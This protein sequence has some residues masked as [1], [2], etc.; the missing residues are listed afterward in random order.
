LQKVGGLRYIKGWRIAIVAT[1][2]KT[3]PEQT[4]LSF[5]A[6]ML[7]ALLL[8]TEE[9]NG[10]MT[11]ST[12]QL[13]NLLRESRLL[14]PNQIDVLDKEFAQLNGTA[15]GGDA[16]ALSQWLISR[17]AISP[18]QSKILLAG[19]SGPFFY[20]EYKVFDRVESGR[21]AGMFRAFHAPSRH[22]VL[23]EFLAGP[24]AQD[25][26]MW[27]LISDHAEAQAAIVHPNLNRCYET[28]DLG[29]FKFAALEDL[30][31]EPLESQL[32]R[33]PLPPGEACRVARSVA[34]GLS[35]M[36]M[37]SL[38]H[39]DVRPGNLWMESTGN[40]KLLRDPLALPTSLDRL[41]QSAPEKYA[42]LAD[43]VAP[44]LAQPGQK[45][46]ALSDL[47]ALGCTLYQL[48]SARPPFPGGDISHKLQRHAA[49]AIQPLEQQ[50]VPQPIAQIVTYLMAKNPS[51][52][53][54]QAAVVA[55]QLTPFCDSGKLA[56]Q[57]PPAA[58]SLPAYEK[59]LK[60]DFAADQPADAPLP[61]AVGG[62]AASTSAGSG[63]A[64]PFV[65]G[66]D[67][68]RRGIRKPKPKLSEVVNDPGALLTRQN[69]IYLASGLTALILLLIVAIV[70]VT[71]GREEKPT[72]S[73]AV[74][75][76]TPDGATTDGSTSDGASADGQS[77]EGRTADGQSDEGPQPP[78]G[79]ETPEERSGVEIITVVPDDGELL[80]DS[81]TRGAPISLDYA[82][83]GSL[84]YLVVR[85]AAMIASGEGE[86]VLRALGPNIA[87]LRQSFESA[88]GFPLE[89]IDQLI[90]TIHGDGSGAVRPAFVVRPR[91][92][93]TVEDVKERWG[94]P[95]ETVSEGER[96]YRSGGWAFY[97]PP[98]AD[99]K[100]FTMAAEPE[101][102]DV[103]EKH[104]IPLVSS[105][106][107]MLLKSTDSDRHVNLLFDPN[108]IKIPEGGTLLSGP[109]TKLRP[110]LTWFLGEDNVR[111]SLVSM[112][113][114]PHFYVE[115]RIL[116]DG[117]E[118]QFEVASALRRRLKT[119]PDAI[120][121]YMTRINPS[122]YW[123]KLSYRLVPMVGMLAE[124]TRVGTSGNEAVV[125]AV[126]PPYAASNLVIAAELLITS[127]PGA[128]A[129]AAGPTKKTPQSLEELLA[130]KTTI[131]F[132]QHDLINA[133]ALV[134]E[135][136]LDTY[137]DLPFS[138]DI[139]MN[140]TH[141]MEEGITQNQAVRDF[142]MKDKSI[143]EILTAMM[144]KANPITTVKEPTE[145]DQKLVWVADPGAKGTILITTR[146]AAKREGYP[147]PAV[148]A[149]G[150]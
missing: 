35:Q 142:D 40:V 54:Q 65:V 7:S 126:L 67:P 58:K 113:F 61:P 23:L 130:V 105:E 29:A 73:D 1:R 6:E 77:T 34:L 19:R 108:F 82:P 11:V 94:D 33:G 98:G 116:A 89:E 86:K 37:A 115:T 127:E 18:Y 123:K 88:S 46:D 53:Y 27:R 25:G 111:S 120:E 69:L 38:A 15:Q 31:G 79:F 138:F 43:Y 75:A 121:R 95:Q 51:V 64:G 36:H 117:D 104:G 28:V 92:S 78:G 45:P 112:H 17:K 81:P 103:I 136:L 141:L 63:G 87:A 97:I 70:M 8:P 91:S 143:S 125:N 96:Y 137:P 90:V 84:V 3:K 132:P 118:N 24:A 133:V 4:K 56:I 102:A 107:S 10:P 41:Q 9:C 30:R 22:P 59:H 68:R 83:S 80:W 16:Q 26:G 99:G 110:Q 106:I 74:A 2:A 49:E 57:P 101:I 139:K 52:R 72:D 76:S 66:D 128:A 149:P 148:F 55:E 146:K 150:S 71:M 93:F 100:V 134:K 48:L 21:L 147:L 14:A 47:Y 109:L 50:G 60:S 131:Q 140:G 42:A 32:T 114:S 124:Q 129:V 20:G 122:V 12:P 145:E 5:A 119:V 39:G 62:A 13:W 85:P 135:D 144:M 44:E